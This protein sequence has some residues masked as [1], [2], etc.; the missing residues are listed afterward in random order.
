MFRNFKY[1]FRSQIFQINNRG[2]L[3]LSRQFLLEQID[4]MLT[5]WT[6]RT[7]F[8]VGGFH[9]T[10]RDNE[11]LSNYQLGILS[12]RWITLMTSRL[13]LNCYGCLIGFKSEIKKTFI[14][15]VLI[16]KFVK[17]TLILSY[18]EWY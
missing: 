10:S 7:W 9:L 1:D 18:F 12:H 17:A 4:I 15:T 14:S 6:S 5:K 3:E 8:N 13:K 16:P 2:W 11:I